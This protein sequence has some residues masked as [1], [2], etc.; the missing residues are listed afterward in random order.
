[1]NDLRTGRWSVSDT[2]INEPGSVHFPEASLLAKDLQRS[3]Q[4]NS[5]KVINDWQFVD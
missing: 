1:M 3:S 2:A 5:Q 4:D